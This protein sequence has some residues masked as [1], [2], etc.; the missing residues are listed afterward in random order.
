MIEVG[1]IYKEK[2]GTVYVISR[3]EHDF[4]CIIYNDGYG[5]D[6][7]LIDDNPIPLEDIL[8]AEYPTW[9]EAIRSPEFKG[10]QNETTL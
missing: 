9:Q 10:V 3:I 6:Y 7:P 4:Y 2:D 5:D 1:Q 8:I